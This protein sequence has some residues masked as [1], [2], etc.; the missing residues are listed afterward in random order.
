MKRVIALFL[1]LTLLL[2]GCA[3]VEMP[4]VPTGDALGEDQ[5]Q[6]PTQGQSDKA[7]S[8]AYYP[9]RSL[10]PYTCTDTTNRVVLSLIYQGL[11]TVDKSYQASPM[12]CQSY[13]MSRDMRTYV[14]YVRADATFSDGT[15][16]TGADV[17]ASLQA[18]L[19]SPVYSG[20]F[21]HVNSVKL[22]QDGGVEVVLNTP[23]GDL[24]VLLDVPIIKASQIEA[25]NP[26]GTGPY[27]LEDTVS[28]QWLRRRT[29]WWCKSEDLVAT[30]DFI[31]LTAVTSATDARNAFEAQKV[32]LVCADP[33]SPTFAEFRCDYELWNC[34]NGQFLYLALNPT[35]Q[36]FNSAMM[37][38]ALARSINREALVDTY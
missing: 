14:F 23:Y 24:P 33:G 11:F 4:Y 18:A 8:L 26:L 13:Q 9:E 27:L 1:A 35:R 7:L 34:E 19:K 30:A 5:V 10:N 12:L 38:N 15:H 29:V 6:T 36:V 22:L 37:R 25:E 3:T 16:I 21:G 28:G 20:R 31:P 32:S 2:S 17:E